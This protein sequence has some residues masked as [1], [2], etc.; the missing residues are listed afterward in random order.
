VELCSFYGHVILANFLLCTSCTILIII[1]IM[2]MIHLISVVKHYRSVSAS[3]RWRYTNIAYGSCLLS[4]VSSVLLKISDCVAGCNW[5]MT[6]PT[7]CGSQSLLAEVSTQHRL[8]SSCP[9]ISSA[10]IVPS[11][12]VCDLGPIYWRRSVDANAYTTNSV[13]PLGHSASFTEHPRSR[14]KLPMSMF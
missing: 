11:S 8:S 4:D 14:A 9:T 1:I 13:T 6:R 7:S 12:T 5:T 2:Y 10:G 3:V